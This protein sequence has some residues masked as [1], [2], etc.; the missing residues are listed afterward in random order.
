MR[1]SMLI[2]QLFYKIFEGNFALK[3]WKF[4]WKVRTI[5]Q[6][7]TILFIQRWDEQ[8]QKRLEL[9]HNYSLEC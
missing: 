1:S 3:T 8:K 9:V 6:D 7:Q 2:Y 5:Q 4:I